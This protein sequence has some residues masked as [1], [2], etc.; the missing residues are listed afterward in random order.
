MNIYS[1]RIINLKVDLQ[2]F[3]NSLPLI[4][5][6]KQPADRYW[7]GY[8]YNGY[9]ILQICLSVASFPMCLI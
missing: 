1:Y 6:R 8:E 3:T 5:Y 7:Y 9:A 4:S 2:P